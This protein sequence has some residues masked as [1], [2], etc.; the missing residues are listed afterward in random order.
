MRR[1]AFLKQ[2]NCYLSH[3]VT[4]TNKDFSNSAA[5][6]FTETWLND[7]IPDGALH[8]PGYQ[9]FRADRDT[10]STGK[11][12]GGGTCFYINER[13]CTDV[14]VLKK[15]CCSDLEALF[16][17][18]KPFYSPREFCSI[19]LVSVHIP[20]QANVSLALQ[21]LADQIADTEQKHPDSVLIILGDF[22]KANL[23]RELPK[24]SQHVTCP[25]RDSNI[26]YHCYTVIKDAYRFVPRAALGLSDHC[27]VHLIPTY[28]QKLKSAKPVVKT[29]KRWTNETER[30]LQACFEWTDWSVFETAATDLDELTE[31]VTSYISFCEDICIPTG[32]YLTFNN[33]KPW[34]TAKLRHLRQAKEDAY[35]KGDRVLYNQARNTLNKEIRAAKRTYAKRLEDQFASNDPTSVWKGLKA[36]T[37]Y[38][39]PSPSTEVNQQLAEDLNEFYCRFE[40]PHTRSD[41]LLTQPLTPPT[42][43]SSPPPAL[44]ISEEDVRQ[45][46][47]KNKRRKAPGPDG[48]T[49]A[50]LKTCADQ[51][52]PI[53]LQIFNRSLEL[54]E[55]P[56]C[57]KHST[58]IPV[59]KKP[60]IT[61]LNDYR[62]V[63]L[64]SVIMKSLEKLV[65]A[66]LK[67]ITGPLLDPLQFAYRANRSVDDAVNMGLHFILQHL[68]R[69]GTYVRILFV[70]F[71]SAFNTIIPTLLQTKLNQLSVPSSICQWITSFLTDR[72]QLVRMGTLMSS[73]RTTN[74][75]APQGCVLSPLLFSLYTNDCT[76]K[77]PSVKLLKFADDTTLIGLIQDGEE[78]AYRQEVEQLAVRC[79]LNNLELN[80][81]KTVEMV[82]DFRRN[83]PALPPLSI[84]DSTV[85]A[86]ETFKFLGSIISRDLKWDTHIDSRQSVIAKK[87]Q[88][89]LYLPQ[90]L[91]KQFYSAVTESVLCTSITVW[92]GSATKSDTRR[93]QRTVRTAERIIGAPL[94]T[95]QELYTSRVRKRAQ[96]ITL[97]P[98]HP[99]HPLFKLLQSGRR[100]R[101]T[102]TRTARHKNSFFPRAIYLMNS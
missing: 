58:I 69:P 49:P 54:C 99:C 6:C 74:T 71:S 9:L 79:S 52:A 38:K 62:P 88:Q 64:M 45:V 2:N 65:L 76:S 89:R 43:P 68:D 39:T 34:F 80:T 32:T 36:I 31:T 100:Y 23:S 86:V 1:T 44:Q 4:R 72:Q 78:S 82:I 61:G 29:V 73:S 42:N 11:S 15:M 98:S 22:N 81:L 101:A 60:K 14:T 96:K 97:D 20:P 70:D 37:N 10:E 35:R 63:A 57:F 13:W 55:V 17:D 46:F 95:L 3:R 19:I 83:P 48:V 84:M 94:P 28:R 12:R 50:C 91:L 90:E 67:D 92:F 21:K 40:I 53:F 47:R 26:L 85:A 7:A 16:I 24:Y 5:L 77:D 87:A 25:T 102:N 30:V 66:Y 75:G 93:L 18:C 51:L 27:L 41:H 56:S 33:D 8:L 59:P